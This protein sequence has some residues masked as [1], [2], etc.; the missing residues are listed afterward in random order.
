MRIAQVCPRYYPYIGGIETHVKEI[1]ERLMMRNFEVEVLTTD[2]SGKLP[3]EEIIN[4]IKVRRF[5]LGRQ[6]KT[7]IFLK[8]LGNI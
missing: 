2:P 8:N 3:K 7:I 6:M 4:C 1:S 5:S